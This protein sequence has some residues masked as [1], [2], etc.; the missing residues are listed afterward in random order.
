M[1][2]AIEILTAMPIYQFHVRA[3][4][5]EPDVR[6]SHLADV[7]A[8]KRYARSLIDSFKSNHHFNADYRIEIKDDSGRPIATIPFE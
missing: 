7:E 8:A 5:A 4:H 1:R 3:D 6:W 2:L